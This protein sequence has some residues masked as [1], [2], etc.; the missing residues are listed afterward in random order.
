MGYIP[1][2]VHRGY[3]PRGVHIGKD[4]PRELYPA[5]TPPREAIPRHIHHLG[6]NRVYMSYT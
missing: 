5:Y 1:R 4:T 6:Y 2:G 3:I